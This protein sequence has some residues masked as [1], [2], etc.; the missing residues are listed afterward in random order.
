[1]SYTSHD[2]E[3]FG[4]MVTG[5]HLWWFGIFTRPWWWMVPWIWWGGRL[6]SPGTMPSG[7]L[8]GEFLKKN[9]GWNSAY[10]LGVNNWLFKVS[11]F[12]WTGDVFFSCGWWL[13]G[14]N[15]SKFQHME[16]H[17]DDQQ[18]YGEAIYHLHQGRARVCRPSLE[19]HLGKSGGLWCCSNL[20]S[21]LATPLFTLEPMK[22][23]PVDGFL[24][25]SLGLIQD[26]NI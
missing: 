26:N 18:V 23:T 5:S 9:N 16:M 20:V 22:N 1:M 15:G 24:Y 13:N 19:R 14:T 21:R 12:F 25:V 3:W 2:W 17:W 6:G 11:F 8:S 10:F 4:W 7:D